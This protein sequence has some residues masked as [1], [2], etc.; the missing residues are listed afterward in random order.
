M[1]LNRWGE[2]RIDH[3]ADI[4]LHV[5]AV[6]WERER[7]G[8]SCL[9]QFKGSCVGNATNKAA[10]GVELSGSQKYPLPFPKC[11]ANVS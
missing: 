11:Y 4:N 7:D 5:F 6:L 3:M 2:A 9:T 1:S 8:D 10:S